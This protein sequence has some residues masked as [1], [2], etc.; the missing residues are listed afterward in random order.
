M[1]G[2]YYRT[3]LGH[4]ARK[5]DFDSEKTTKEY[6]EF[7]QPDAIIVPAGSAYYFPEELALRFPNKTIIDSFTIYEK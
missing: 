6:L 7:L 4:F 5:N 2:Y 1:L 3:G